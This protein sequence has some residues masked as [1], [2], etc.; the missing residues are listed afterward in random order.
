M[1]ALALFLSLFFS[2]GI[3]AQEQFS[4]FFDS[5][6]FELKKSENDKLQAWID[7]HTQDKIVAINGYTDEDGTTGFND[8]LAQKRVN[9]IFKATHGKVKIRDDFKTR[10]FGEQHNLSKN[11]AEN[12]KVTIYFIEAKDLP[13]EN[14]ILGIKPEP[15]VVKEKPPV[16]YP[17]NIVL[18]N[19][20]GSKTEFQLDVA[21]MKQVGEAKVGEKLKIDNLNF[22][23]NTFAVV[24]ESRR[25]L[26]E[27][28][29]VME[30]NPS[31]KI[32]IQGHLCCMP[33]D[34]QDLST[35]RAK[36]IQQFLI[37]N[38]IANERITY[39][40]FGSS[41]PIFPIPE[42]DEPQRAANRRVEIAIV[43]N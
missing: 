34:K 19:P 6:K 22:I 40:G 26:Y 8:T 32:E 3:A 13:R 23:I 14:E 11:K 4:V 1:K 2:V 9:T 30:K 31:L 35:K 29:I 12:R 17:K 21:F 42:K 24:P 27:L 25:K 39:K 43:A 10:S 18:E 41:Q 20:D 28:L 37:K 5:N 33:S 15:P 7:A 36:A 16:F 38:G